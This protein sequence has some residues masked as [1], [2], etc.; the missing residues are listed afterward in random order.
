MFYLCEF[1]V[2]GFRC[3]YCDGIPEEFGLKQNRMN[4]IKPDAVLIEEGSKERLT[5]YFGAIYCFSWHED[6]YKL[7]LGK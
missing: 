6:L 7:L 2:D 1:D 5:T 3:D 4:A